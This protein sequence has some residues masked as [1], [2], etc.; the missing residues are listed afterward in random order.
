MNTAGDE[1]DQ[2]DM[3]RLI[4]GHDAALDNLMERHGQRLFHYLLRQLPESEAEDCTQETFRPHL[5][6]PRKIPCRRKVFDLA[7]RHCDQSGARLPAAKNAAS[8]GFPGRRERPRGRGRDIAGNHLRQREPRRRRHCWPGSG[9][10]KCARR[11]GRCRRN[12]AKR[13]SCMNTKICPAGDCGNLALHAQGGGNAHLP[14][15]KFAPQIAGGVD[16][17][18]LTRRVAAR[19]TRQPQFRPLQTPP[20]PIISSQPEKQSSCQHLI[21]KANRS[22]YNSPRDGGLSNGNSLH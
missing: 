3:G 8:G 21:S 7:L 1:A 12:C 9:Q 20:V 11:C 4:Q 19:G 10:R 6:S 15:A 18:K 17:S 13:W 22:F 5:P 2:L 16:G 14:R